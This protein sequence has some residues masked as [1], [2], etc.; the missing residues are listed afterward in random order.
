ME[1]NFGKSKPEK[2]T[3]GRSI[4][5]PFRLPYIVEYIADL[6][7]RYLVW[8]K[9]GIP[10]AERAFQ[11]KFPMLEVAFASTNFG[12]V[13]VTAER[14]YADEVDFEEG[15]MV[16]DG[17]LEDGEIPITQRRASLERS[18]GQVRVRKATLLSLIQG[19]SVADG[20]G[21]EGDNDAKRIKV[22]PDNSK[23]QGAATSAGDDVAW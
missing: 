6:E 5:E 1:G 14:Y 3:Y 9:Q 17:E 2:G 13:T 22:V 10:L 7:K 23:D 21:K 18:P 19:R 15:A 11:C 12:T 8:H 4:P 20:Y 16:I